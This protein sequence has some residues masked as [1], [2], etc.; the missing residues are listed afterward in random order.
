M[1]GFGALPSNADRLEMNQ[2]WVH[3]FYS[4]RLRYSLVVLRNTVVYYPDLT[5]FFYFET[6]DHVRTTLAKLN[7]SNRPSLQQLSGN[8]ITNETLQ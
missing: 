5:F 7:T 4:G 3:Q 1:L 6:P 2:E 8:I